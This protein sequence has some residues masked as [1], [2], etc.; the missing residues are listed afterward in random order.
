M[1]A[2]GIV[3]G[4]TSELGPVD[5]QILKVRDKSF[6]WFSAFN[7]VTSYEKLLERAINE[8]GNLPPLLQQLSYYDPQEI[9]ELRSAIALSDDIAVKALASGMLQGKS[10]KQIKKDISIFLDPATKKVHGRAV[11]RGEAEECGLVIMRW[12]NGESRW[13]TLYELY[14]RTDGLLSS[15]NLLKC[16]ETADDFWVGGS[17]ER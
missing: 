14:V 1:G 10:E 5:P 2:E 9:E 11:H 3:M 15:Q 16:S 6:Q 4:P 17:Y 7:L 12:E 8:T 13:R